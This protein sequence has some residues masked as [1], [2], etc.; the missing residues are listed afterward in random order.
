MSKSAP[1]GEFVQSGSFIVQGKRRFVKNARLELGALLW[2]D[3]RADGGGANG[4][5]STDEPRETMLMVAPYR[6]SVRLRHPTA[7]C[8][9]LRRPVKIVPGRGKRGRTL[10]HIMNT[11]QIDRGSYDALDITVR[12][13]I[14]V[15]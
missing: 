12:S 5:G 11:L 15:S 6:T 13:G 2:A 9:D 7:H 8:P 10:R 4:A 14:R 3:H 1:A